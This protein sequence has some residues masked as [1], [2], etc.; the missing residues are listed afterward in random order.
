MN[1]NDNQKSIASHFYRP[2]VWL[3]I[4]LIILLYLLIGG[5]FIHFMVNNRVDKAYQKLQKIQVES[6]KIKHQLTMARS[7]LTGIRSNYQYYINQNLLDL[8]IKKTISPF[9]NIYGFAYS[10]NPLLSHFGIYIYQ[11]SQGFSKQSLTTVYH[12]H[13]THYY[14]RTWYKK[15]FESKKPYISAPKP[16]WSG[17]TKLYTIT[18][19]F[20]FSSDK[21]NQD[22]IYAIGA[23]DISIDYVFKEL[24]Q[25][26]KSNNIYINMRDSHDQFELFAVHKNKDHID[27]KALDNQPVSSAISQEKWKLEGL[28]L[29]LYKSFLFN[30]LNMVIE[31]RLLDIVFHLLVLLI[32]LVFL[33]WLSMWWVRR[34]VNNKIHRLTRPITYLA[35]RLPR[36]AEKQHINEPI[37]HDNIK[38][39]EVYKLYESTERMRQALIHSFNLQAKLNKKQYQLDLAR[40]IQYA[41]MKQDKT[42]A[43]LSRHGIE[44]ATHYQAASDLSGDI[45]E[46]IY[47]GHYAYM[48]VGDASGKDAAATIFSLF[49]L[50]RFRILAKEQQDPVTIMSELNAYLCH[51]N[52]EN[53]FL[54]L[55]CLRIDV[56]NQYLMLANAGHNKPIILDY[57]HNFL[58]KHAGDGDLV[59]GIDPDTH[60]HQFE[61]ATHECK[62]IIIYSDGLSE[63]QSEKGFLGTEAIKKVAKRY[64]N[65]TSEYILRKIIDTVKAYQSSNYSQDDETLMVIKF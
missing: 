23:F 19:S 22:F 58:N 32:V 49:I 64:Q 52:S 29:Y 12:K 5:F 40:R 8:L 35:E 54:T 4:P 31:I 57:N 46:I 28:S 48:V 62:V 61:L 6:Q 65:E 37:A 7:I 26:I 44:I 17:N 30:H 39:Q 53:M 41:F 47:S 43:P 60:Y 21:Q 27:F 14:N 55:L 10:S 56:N 11:T 45:Y 13:N 34:F 59:L 24:M 3:I 36:I 51:H 38:G 33:V 18:Y 16:T 1:N 9:D 42:I 15:A 25:Y 63:A 20:P 2:F 50:S